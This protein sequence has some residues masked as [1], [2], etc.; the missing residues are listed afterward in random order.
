MP[1]QN[2]KPQPHDSF[3]LNKAILLNV[4]LNGIE[5]VK[6]SDIHV[7][8]YIRPS[9][10]EHIINITFQRKKVVILPN[11]KIRTFGTILCVIRAWP[12]IICTHICFYINSLMNIS[13]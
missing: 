7:W 4:L 12:Y 2:D 13:K 6:Q 9:W 11:Y 5:Y 3:L 1:L 10:P 8:F